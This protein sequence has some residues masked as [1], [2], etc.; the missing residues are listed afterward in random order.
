MH[1]A[2]VKS[3]TKPSQASHDFTLQVSCYCKVPWGWR[4]ISMVLQKFWFIINVIMNVIILMVSWMGVQLSC[5]SIRSGVLLMQVLLFSVAKDFSP[6]VNFQSR[7]WQHSYCPLQGS[8]WEIPVFYW[9]WEGRE[10]A[11]RHIGYYF[12]CS[13]TNK[14]TTEEKEKEKQHHQLS[15]CVYVHVCVY[16]CVCVCVCA[17]TC[18]CVWQRVFVFVLH[19]EGNKVVASEAW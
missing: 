15:V 8:L 18:V 1:S 7:L 11:I 14:Q 6:A 3:E 4:V 13:K 5:F 9:L 19:S 16:V 12:V 2:V 17:C 10:S